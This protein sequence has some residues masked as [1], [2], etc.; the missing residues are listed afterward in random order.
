MGGG[1]SRS[2]REAQAALQRQQQQALETQNRLMTQ[3]ETPDP[4]AERLR[5]QR[6]LWLDATEG[7]NGP[8]DVTKLEGMAPYLDLYNRGRAKREGERQGIGLL[9]MG[10]NASNPDLAARLAEQRGAEREQEA[11]GAFSNAYNMK[12]A[13][14]RESIMPL[15]GLQQNRDMGLAGLSSSNYNNATDQYVRMLNRPRQ[16][17]IWG[18]I[19]GG[20][21]GAA[22]SIGSAGITAG[23]I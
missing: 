18:S 2:E 5:T 17:S 16:P 21:L 22:G 7:K 14:M 4:L 20:A 13:E 19:L 15:L 6:M 12:D 3:A 11:A 8:V 9:R 10:V 23:R 1:P